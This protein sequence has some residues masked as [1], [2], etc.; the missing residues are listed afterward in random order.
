MLNKNDIKQLVVSVG[1]VHRLSTMADITPATI[2]RFM[3]GERNPSYQS[4]EKLNKVVETLETQ[5]ENLIN[6]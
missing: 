3:S 5:N 4:L 2:Y 6:A 1:G